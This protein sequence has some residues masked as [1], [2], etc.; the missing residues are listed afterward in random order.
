M[1]QAIC[2]AAVDEE[3]V[4]NLLLSIE[5]ELHNRRRGAAVRLEI[6]DSIDDN[7]LDYLL[8]SLNLTERDVLKIKGPINLYRLMKLPDLVNRDD[9]KFSSFEAFVPNALCLKS[10]LFNQISKADFLLH[11]PYDSFVPIVDFLRQ[12]AIDPS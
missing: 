3:E 12:A 6:D 10:N 7:V 9:L 8:K 1:R 4:E 2:R 5:D 11:H